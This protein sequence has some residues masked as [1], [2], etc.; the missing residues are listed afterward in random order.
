MGK[1]GTVVK[2]ETDKKKEKEVKI[3]LMITK[4]SR[5]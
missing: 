1:S 5:V 3:E 4:G 2:G